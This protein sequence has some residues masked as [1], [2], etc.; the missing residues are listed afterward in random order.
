LAEFHGTGFCE[1]LDAS[2]EKMEQRLADAVRCFPSHEPTMMFFGDVSERGG[3]AVM[4][5]KSVDSHLVFSTLHASS[6]PTA[7]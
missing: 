6:I 5:R 3:A 2:T 1:Q 7:V 4:L